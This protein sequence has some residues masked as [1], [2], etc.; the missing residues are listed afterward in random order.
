MLLQQLGRTIPVAEAAL[1]PDVPRAR[2]D[3]SGAASLCDAAGGTCS[4]SDNEDT[5]IEEC[6]GAF[7]HFCPGSWYGHFSVC[8]LVFGDG[9]EGVAVSA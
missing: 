1:R 9:W 6:L 3:V 2:C 4:S 7:H 5:F 8:T